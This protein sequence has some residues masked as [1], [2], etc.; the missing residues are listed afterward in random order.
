MSMFRN[1]VRD[2]MIVEGFRSPVWPILLLVSFL[3]LYATIGWTAWRLTTA[4]TGLMAAILSVMLGRLLGSIPGAVR[5][6][7]V[8]QI[9]INGNVMILTNDNKELRQIAEAIGIYLE[10][11]GIQHAGSRNFS[12]HFFVEGSASNPYSIPSTNDLPPKSKS[13]LALLIYAV[14]MGPDGVCSTGYNL[15][16]G[17][18]W[19]VLS[20]K[21]GD[22]IENKR[23]SPN[24]LAK[25]I[26]GQI[27]DEVNLVV[28]A[29]NPPNT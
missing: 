22:W 12:K 25:K 9:L 16:D 13:K 26:V 1:T 29:A 28:R 20:T 19:G 5:F 4:I 2:G 17:G 6:S 8:R 11:L 27:F 21:Q 24:Q 15:I 14:G 23:F 18:G 3:A 10:H 7:S